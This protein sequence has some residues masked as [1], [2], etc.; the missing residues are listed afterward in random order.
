MSGI[1]D[2]IL[3]PLSGKLL[4]DHEVTRRFVQ[5]EQLWDISGRG[6]HKQEALVQQYQLKQIPSH[7]GGCLLTDPGFGR[8]MKL[9]NE[10]KVI[11]K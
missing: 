5:K 2:L 1:G 8:K 11:T 7:G 10:E 9:F 3:R 6:V 4:E